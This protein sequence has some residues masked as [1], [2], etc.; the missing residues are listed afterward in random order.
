MDESS[1]PE[2]DDASGL[3]TEPT[4]ELTAEVFQPQQ[5]QSSTGTKDIMEGVMSGT[6]GLWNDIDGDGGVAI[7]FS[8]THDLV[9]TQSGT[10]H[11]EIEELLEQLRQ[12]TPASRDVRPLRAK[13]TADEPAGWNLSEITEVIGT[14]T[15]SL[16]AVSYTHLTLPTT[17]YV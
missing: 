9:V 10:V 17:P 7:P 6:N 2:N 15:D 4:D 1:E 16:W 11:D 13:I 3:Q 12:L 14:C 8:S 5:F